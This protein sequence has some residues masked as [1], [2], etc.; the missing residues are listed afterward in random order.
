MNFSPDHPNPIVSC[1]L[2]HP[3][4]GWHHTVTFTGKDGDAQWAEIKATFPDF[5][6][7]LLGLLAEHLP[8][9]TI[10]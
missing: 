2:R 9:G 4:T 8:E 3:G 5:E 7:K 1:M 6:K 10:S